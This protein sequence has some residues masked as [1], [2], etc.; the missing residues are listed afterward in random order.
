MTETYFYL[1][2][3]YI[4]Y[5]FLPITRDIFSAVYSAQIP[6]KDSGGVLNAKHTLHCV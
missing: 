6:M 2:S 4:Y 3:K 1:D 5:I